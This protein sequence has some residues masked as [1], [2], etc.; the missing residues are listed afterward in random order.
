MF[1][2][3]DWDTPLRPYLGPDGRIHLREGDGQRFLCGLHV[4][5]DDVWQQQGGTLRHPGCQPCYRGPWP[6]WE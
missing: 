2:P 4:G 3:Y 6:G 5:E 1:D